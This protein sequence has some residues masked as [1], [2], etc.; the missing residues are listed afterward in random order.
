MNCLNRG[1]RSKFYL[2]LITTLLA[3]P[4]FLWTESAIAGN[5][6]VS[7]VLTYTTGT[8][9]VYNYTLSMSNTGPE[10]L[11]SLWLGWV[12]GS[13]NISNPTSLSNNLGWT[14]AVNGNSSIRYEGTSETAIAT[15]SS[16]L[17]YFSSTSTPSDFLS[18]SS[19]PSVVYGVNAQQFAIENTSTDSEEFTPSIVIPPPPPSITTQPLSQTVLTNST[20]MFTVVATNALYYQWQS[21]TVAIDGAT[22]ST[23][24]LDNV[25]TNFSA[26]YNV[27]VSN[28]TDS[29]VSS[30]AILLVLTAFPPVIT[31]QPAGANALTNSTVTFSVGASN[32]VAFQWLSNSVDIDGATNSSFTLSNVDITDSATYQ[33]VVSNSD[34]S[35]LSSNAVLL[36]GFPAAITSQPTNVNVFVGTPV[37]LQAAADGSP[38][39]H[40][41]WLSNNIPLAGQTNTSLNLGVATAGIAATYSVTASN[42]FGGEAS[43][44]AVVTVQPLLTNTTEKLTVVITPAKSGTVTPNENGKTLTVGKSYTVKAKAAKGFVFSQWSGVADSDQPDLTFIMPSVSNAT[45]TATFIPSPFASNNVAGTYSGLFFDTNNLSNETSGF[46]SATVT[47]A[48]IISGQ[49]KIAGITA[50]FSTTLLADGSATVSLKRHNE[51][52]LLLTMQVDLSGSE[53]VTGT[54]TDTNNSF[55]AALTAYRAGFSAASKATEFAGYYTWIA[56]GAASN[57]P[58]GYSFGTATVSATGSTRVTVS[59]SDGTASTASAGIA[60]NGAVPVYVSLYSGKGSFLAWVTL[61]KSPTLTTNEAFWLKEP[62]TKGSY[63]AGFDLTNLALMAGAYTPLGRGSNALNAATVTEELSGADLTTTNIESISLSTTGVGSSTNKF[64][65]N[66]SGKTGLVTGSFKDPVSGK[67]TAL[68]GA[69]LQE[70]PQGFG[71]FIGGNL[72][73][74]ATITPQ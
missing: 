47:T 74:A 50:T 25:A 26:T 57:A 49:L 67:T 42:L 38:A 18:G 27:V 12:I 53:T 51:S 39:P 13:F 29:I 10:S 28:A 34:A 73:G 1:L 61:T 32:A 72:S 69:V 11:E 6:N 64:T 65:L 58:V 19:G 45:L 41:Q 33:V 68:K 66:I 31:N 22:N 23:L 5:V 8:G 40:F 71:Y 44:N 52:T 30:N 24:E 48:G 63:V 54:V 60:T 16:G 4:I 21:N 35:V 17:F 70:L 2:A 37:T 59:L 7:G 46:F 56:P 36:V 14:S 55:N 43:S 15:G 62:V 3:L 20:V 9:G